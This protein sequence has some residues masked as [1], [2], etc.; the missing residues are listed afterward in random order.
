MILGVQ[1]S[2]EMLEC[3]VGALDDPEIVRATLVAAAERAGATLLQARV[4][5]FPSGGVTGFALLAESHIAI[6]TW[7][8]HAYA[9]VDL[10][11]CGACDT[12]AAA[13]E[14]ARRLRARR[15]H[16]VASTR[17]PA[18]A[19]AEARE[20]TATSAR[21]A[22]P[23]EDPDAL[24]GSATWYAEPWGGH[25]TLLLRGGAPLFEQATPQ[26]R[27]LVMDSAGWGR[28]L[29]LDGR[30][31]VSERDAFF[32]HEMLAHPAL[33]TAPS[34]ARVLIVG[35]G[36]GFTASEVLK[37]AG[38]ERCVLV[39]IDGVVIDAARR[40]L[41]PQP[42]PWR[43]PRL[44][45]RIED[46]VAFAAQVAA[47]SF[48]VVLIDGCDPIGASAVLFGEPFLRA[49]RRALAPDGVLAMQCESP[50]FMPERF[51]DAIA[52]LRRVFPRTAPY[53]APAPIYASGPWGFAH[54]GATV[55]ACEPLAER[56]RAI[57][58][59]TQYWTPAIHRAAFVLPPYVARLLV[60]AP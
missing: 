10:F 53:C 4:H 15:V 31:M 7:P 21:P 48:D 43:D 55:E 26:Q 24:A 25:T 45:V 17:G 11:T 27:V 59:R 20:D 51:R 2:C 35:G 60:D 47:G 40:L 52:T 46:G 1:V 16:A 56:G 8:E 19:G 14:V 12:H 22:R 30:F 9:S 50:F 18:A 13:R 49:C 57:G 32:Y 28:V 38:V 29:A 54:C 37:H 3:D 41:A 44:E 33:A 58:E 34:I 39:E 42:S 6:H 36:D 5:R 23:T